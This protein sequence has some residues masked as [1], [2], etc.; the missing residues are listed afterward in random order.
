MEVFKHLGIDDRWREIGQKLDPKKLDQDS[1]RN[2]RDEDSTIAIRKM[3]RKC[4]DLKWYNL[5][6][7]V[8]KCC[9]QRKAKEM[10]TLVQY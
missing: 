7:A 4:T 9:G 10:E 6:G 3:I 1:L 8:R 5:T 2:I